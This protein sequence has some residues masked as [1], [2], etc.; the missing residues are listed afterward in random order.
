[1]CFK[2]REEL[3]A[4]WRSCSRDPFWQQLWNNAG[5]SDDLTLDA[6][7][8]IRQKVRAN[9]LK[10][11]RVSAPDPADAE[12]T[13]EKPGN[14]VRRVQQCRPAVASNPP[15]NLPVMQRAGTVNEKDAK[16]ANVDKAHTG[17][18]DQ[19]KLGG[20]DQ[21]QDRKEKDDLMPNLDSDDDED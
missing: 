15:K 4:L 10:A 9:S 8:K 2:D 14:A 18:K 6:I 17:K 19:S 12:L 20:Q 21:Q 1:M 5:L 16:N 11:A 13:P 7:D 3:A